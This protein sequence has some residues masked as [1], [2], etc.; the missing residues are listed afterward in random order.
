MRAPTPAKAEAAVP[1]PPVQPPAA[2]QAPMEVEGTG[3]D[4][5]RQKC[6]IRNNR[7]E[8]VSGTK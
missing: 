8:I 2:A 1:P 4:K 3:G 6:E 7:C 5:D